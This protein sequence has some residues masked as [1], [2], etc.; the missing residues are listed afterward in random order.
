[1]R[2]RKQKMREK[3]RFTDSKWNNCLVCTLKN[4]FFLIDDSSTFYFTQ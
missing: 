1:M 2:I 4:G 3:Q